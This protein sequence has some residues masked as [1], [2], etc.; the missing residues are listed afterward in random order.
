MTTTPFG[1][2]GAVQQSSTDNAVYAYLDGM[3]QTV[4][5]ALQKATLA[6]N[7]LK[8]VRE[9]LGLPFIAGPGGEGSVDTGGW[10]NDLEVQAQDLHAMA[11][12]LDQAALDAK[13]GK[14]D[15]IW[16]DA[17]KDLAISALSGDKFRVVVAQSADGVGVPVMVDEGGNQLH[18]DAPLGVGAIQWIPV[19]VAGAVAVQ[20]VEFVGVYLLVKKGL[21]TL[22]TVTEQKTQRTLAEGAKKH[23]DLV[24]AGKATPDQAKAL[25][26]AMYGGAAEFQKQIA[27][28]EAAKTKPS[29]DFTDMLKTLGYVALGVAGLYTIVQLVPKPAPRAAQAYQENPP[30][31][32]SGYAYATG[33]AHGLRGMDWQLAS[34][35]DWDTVVVDAGSYQYLGTRSIDGSSVNVWRDSKRKRYI[36]QTIALTGH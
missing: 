2:L 9:A 12:F 7:T 5:V 24:A 17:R 30:K 10:A 15:L 1:W 6:Y 28:S 35:D 8:K 20:A 11:V 33:I 16:N 21:E 27:A 22:Q 14:R 19:I 36:A 13:A 23:A 31:V 34:N 29:S 18:V 26:N 4:N 3:R 32:H 25:D